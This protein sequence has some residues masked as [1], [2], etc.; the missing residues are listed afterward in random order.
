ML[1]ILQRLCYNTITKGEMQKM[2]V[3]FRKPTQ[4]EVNL[5]IE[6]AN[7]KK[8]KLKLNTTELCNILN[9][10]YG[11]LLRVLSG[12]LVNYQIINKLNSW[13]NEDE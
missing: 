2:N 1:A 11:N 5:I 12:K 10:N 4:A 9:V 3:E 6:M 7:N 8:N 13:I